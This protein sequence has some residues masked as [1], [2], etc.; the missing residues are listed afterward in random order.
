MNQQGESDST[1]A[2]GEEGSAGVEPLAAARTRLMEAAAVLR[3]GYIAALYADWHEV[4]PL[5]LADIF[6]ATVR[7][8]DSSIEQLDRVGNAGVP[9]GAPA[10][11]PAAES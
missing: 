10:D 1:P 7:L 4:Q 11:S 6:T 9:P 5:M 3:A 8:I 2:G